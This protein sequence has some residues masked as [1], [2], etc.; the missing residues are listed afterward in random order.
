M[1][2]QDV[3]PVPLRIG[4]SIAD[5]IQDMYDEITQRAYEIFQ[6]RGGN[7]TLDLEDW[8]TAEREL[9]H[10]P[11]VRIE[12]AG[13]RMVV[14]VYL[15][16]IGP[17]QVQLLVTPDAMLVQGPTPTGSKK[18]FRA[19]QFPRRIDVTKAE[20]LYGDGCLFLVA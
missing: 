10:K 8:L 6:R 13:Q 11:N 20:A 17:L 16:E 3:I 19:V 12:E 9:V 14:T 15:G 18:L 7:A 2:S 1:N 4:E 5:E